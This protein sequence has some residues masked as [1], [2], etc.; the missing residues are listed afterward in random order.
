MDNPS[1]SE[2]IV[3]ASAPEAVYQMVADITRMGEW[4]PVCKK[5]WWD[6]GASGEAGSWFTGH[7]ELGERTWQTRSQVVVADPGHEFAFIVGGDRTRWGYRF[8]AVDGGTKVTESWE[9]LPGNAEA[10][11]ER[12]GANAQA[13]IANRLETAKSGIHA[14]LAAI[15]K[16]AEAA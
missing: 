7:N 4:S 1:Y 6:D 5:C 10:F 15:K 3:I 2:S 12:Y 16:A 9:F 11:K 13:E 8:E 14:T